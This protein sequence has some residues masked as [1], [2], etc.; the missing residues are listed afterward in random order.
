MPLFGGSSA[1][2]VPI[3]TAEAAS[4]ASIE[5]DLPSGYDIFALEMSKL[6]SSNAGQNLYLRLSQDG[7]T[8]WDSATQDYAHNLW[9][10]SYS[11]P[12][13]VT[14]NSTNSTQITRSGSQT[15]ADDTGIS[16]TIRLYAPGDSLYTPMQI[17]LLQHDASDLYQDYQ[18]GA[19]QR[20]DNAAQDAIQLYFTSGT[21]ASGRV[22]LYGMA[23]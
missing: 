20:R 1:G 22:T 10:F 2:L 5:F 18:I 21:I 16:G 9:D 7:G 23:H 3:A 6:K 8:T 12:A 4:D 11:T 19:G 15:A 17:N 13:N 14:Y